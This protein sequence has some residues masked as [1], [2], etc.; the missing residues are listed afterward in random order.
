MCVS[1]GA[2]WRAHGDNSPCATPRQQLRSFYI[3][4]RAARARAF[5]CH[6]SCF[7]SRFASLF[8]HDSRLCR[9]SA[10]VSTDTASRFCRHSASRLCS[11]L[12]SSLVWSLVSALHFSELCS[13]GP[14]L[15][16]VSASP[17]LRSPLLLHSSL[18]CIRSS[19]ATLH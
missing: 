16:R 12:L 11:A 6:C 3:S 14:A 1:Y 13:F 9:R 8:R 5:G 7:R 19:F 2:R 10:F 18:L 4:E 15:P 17:L